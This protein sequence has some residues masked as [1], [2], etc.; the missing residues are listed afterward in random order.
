MDKLS[1]E[2]QCIRNTATWAHVKPTH[3]FDSS[4]FNKNEVLNDL[5]IMSPKI[6][7][8]LNKIKELDAEDMNKDGKYYK[9]IIY[10]DVTG[11]NGAKMVA[12]SMIANDYVL[13]YNNGKFLNDLPKTNKTFGLLTTTVINKKPMSV[14]L[15]K[16]IINTM[17][18]RPKNINGENM[19][20]LILDSGFKE[21]IDVYDVKYMHILEP[22]ITKA[23]TTQV[24][25]RGTRFCGQAG[26]PFIPN[27]G[28]ALNVYR[29]NINY[30]DNMNVHELFIKH[31]NQNISALNFTADIEDI[32]AASSVDMPLTEN[33]HT[34]IFKNN[35]FYV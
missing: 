32:M 34:A 9:H 16:T 6:H 27:K 33:I 7:A 24:I 15:K 17:N 22:L 20:F 21:G 1:K 35:R 31:S 3:K 14:N 8:M 29:Y 12:S 5:P 11:T 10:S 23:E 28:W 25:G 19:R 4:K 13:S 2:A 26:L 30:N 18:E